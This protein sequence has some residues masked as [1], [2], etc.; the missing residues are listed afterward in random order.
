[1]NTE[2]TAL[3]MLFVLAFVLPPAAASGAEAF[4]TGNPTAEGK[5]RGGADAALSRHA[6]SMRT[7][8]AG[9][10]LIQ[11]NR[12]DLYGLAL[13]NTLDYRTAGPRRWHNGDGPAFGGHAGFA[14]MPSR[15]FADPFRLWRRAPTH[16][17]PYLRGGFVGHHRLEA[18]IG[19]PPS[20]VAL[21][22]K[23]IGFRV[24]EIAVRAV[25]AADRES[26]V[27]AVPAL[28]P[29]A[30]AEVTSLTVEFQWR[31]TG[32]PGLGRPTVNLK[33]YGRNRA[34]ALGDERGRWVPATLRLPLP[35]VLR[36]ADLTLTVVSETT[37]ELSR[38]VVFR[39]V[40]DGKGER[41][42]RTPVPDEA[43]RLRTDEG[44]STVLID[45]TAATFEGGA[46]LRDVFVAARFEAVE[47]E[48]IRSVSVSYRFG[49]AGRNRS[50]D[51]EL[52]VNGETVARA[53][54]RQPKILSF[55]EE[56]ER[57]L[58]GAVEKKRDP[59]HFGAAVFTDAWLSADFDD[60]PTRVGVHEE[61]V[62]YQCFSASPAVACRLAPGLAVGLSLDFYY[63][64]FHNLDTLLAQPPSLL[65][66]PGGSYGTT[67]AFY[68]AVTGNDAVLFQFDTDKLSAFGGGA[69]AGVIWEP[70]EAVALGLSAATPAFLTRHEGEAVVDF[71]DE[72]EFSDFLDDL[73]ASL[74]LPYGG[75]SGFEARYDVSL[76]HFALPA[77]LSAG[78]ALRPVEGL[79]L[80]ADVTFLPWTWA[81]ED[82]LE[83]RFSGG[84][85]PDLNVLLGG[86]GFTARVPFTLRD[87]LVV[88]LGASAD[89]SP[90][91]TVHLGYRYATDPVEEEE[92]LPLF[93]LHLCH[94]ASMGLTY[95]VFTF[96]F[97]VAVTHGFG[98]TAETGRSVHTSSWDGDALYAQEN[99]L[100]VGVSYR[101]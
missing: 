43:L 29:L 81:R 75:Q 5:G 52:V 85:N 12:E 8:P 92:L 60:R 36:P 59:W 74:P 63:S 6:L 2:R 97:H 71:S 24:G 62:R 57:F 76:R 89:L 3:R 23:G 96:A 14:F 25:V 68:A 9:M 28:D 34:T 22:V 35:G 98:R 17:A 83:F 26:R 30:G 94:H 27:Y 11:G 37:V 10:G 19:A 70:D 55:D 95:R 88:A 73:Q 42:V 80:A 46:S 18:A 32:P 15:L 1:M 54:H 82:C 100:L 90:Q 58:R 87:Q 21:R 13:W 4:L 7:N 79:V 48:K 45:A 56:R 65:E 61:Q 69:H 39:T 44:L 33:A 51:V 84:S 77:K 16:D 86:D 20:Q 47:Q 38:V 78:V 67:G 53:T 101:Y 49:F 50:G 40:R 31:Q 91:W 93:P 99:S 72:F 66:G 64:R 41:V